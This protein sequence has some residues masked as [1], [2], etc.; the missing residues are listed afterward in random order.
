MKNPK[1][2]IIASVIGFFFSFI[3][4]LVAGAGFGSA[5]LRAVI[6]AVVCCIVVGAL[7]FA[8]Q[9][10]LVESDG[11]FAVTE[12]VDSG[13]A[14]SGSVVN[15]MLEDE[16]LPSEPDDPRFDVRNVSAAVIQKPDAGLGA[17]VSSVSQDDF[18]SSFSSLDSGKQKA[19]SSNGF[20]PASITS[21]AKS[22]S[23]AA[24]SSRLAAVDSASPR[25]TAPPENAGKAALLGDI[26]AASPRKLA[27]SVGAAPSESPVSAEQNA[28]ASLGG[29]LVDL[30][31]IGNLVTEGLS[32]EDELIKDTDFASATKDEVA[33]GHKN[34]TDID[35]VDVSDSKAI[36]S[37]IRTLLVS[38]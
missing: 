8:A 16:E 5:L 32:S 38:G 24:A 12:S 11:G 17:A 37:A 21:V 13:Q 23:P 25:K 7:S 1:V 26:D 22:A 34:N 18:M 30:P 4:S 3:V 28:G 14:P 10:F 33:A 6:S 35:D 2:L 29:G 36:A 20:T 9:K 27:P 19:A 15:I 31:D